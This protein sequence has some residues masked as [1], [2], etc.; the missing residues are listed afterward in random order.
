M[1]AVFWDKAKDAALGIT[2]T[3]SKTSANLERQ[4]GFAFET[5]SS[6]NYFQVRFY[7]MHSPPYI[8]QVL[9]SLPG[10]LVFCRATMQI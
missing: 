6:G 2:L 10:M 5:N 1:P 8:I 4:P 3:T 7:R 9:V